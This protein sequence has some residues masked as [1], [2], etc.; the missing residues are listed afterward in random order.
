[1]SGKSYR[2]YIFVRAFE[3]E[4]TSHICSFPVELDSQLPTEGEVY[5]AA[6]LFVSNGLAMWRLPPRASQRFAFHSYSRKAPSIWWVYLRISPCLG[7]DGCRELDLKGTCQ[8]LVT[9][10][11]HIQILVWWWHPILYSE[12]HVCSCF[13][14]QHAPPFEDK[15]YNIPCKT[16]KF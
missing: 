13:L 14:F 16:G 1:M 7:F 3:S 10:I 11:A 9:L 6:A 15:E 12:I 5:S 4:R 8:I 2:T